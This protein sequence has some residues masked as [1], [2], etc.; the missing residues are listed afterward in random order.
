M[1]A[2]TTLVVP[3]ASERLLAELAEAVAER[4]AEL[5]LERL[6]QPAEVGSS[7]YLNVG[8][9]AAYL[10]CERQRIYDLLSSRR[11]TKLKDGSRVLV[12]R[13]ELDALIG[14]APV[15]PPTPQTLMAARDAA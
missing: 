10:R 11:L 9:A 13:A 2:P 6:G 12:L 1:T 4:A 7:P 3:G 15:L 5:V 14:V 8:E